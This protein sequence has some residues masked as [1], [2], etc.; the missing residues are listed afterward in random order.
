[1]NYGSLSSNEKWESFYAIGRSL[2]AVHG[3]GKGK[4]TPLFVVIQSN[5]CT[6]HTLKH[7][8]FNI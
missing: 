1:M 7:N 3:K 2:G 5:S 6:I 4:V 8:H